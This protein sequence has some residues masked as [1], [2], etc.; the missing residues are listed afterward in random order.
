MRRLMVA[1]VA[2]MIGCYVPP[3]VSPADPDAVP[4][5]KTHRPLVT[6][7]LPYHL[8]R[9]KVRA[10]HLANGWCM[11]RVWTNT[12]EFYVCLPE[13]LNLKTPPMYAMARYDAEGG[14]IAYATFTPVPCRMYGRCDSVYGRTVYAGEH[15]FVDHSNGLYDRLSERA[16]ADGN[17]TVELPSMQMKM[18]DALAAELRRRFGIPQWQDPHRFGAMWSTPTSQI[19]LF[20][21]GKGGWVVE[22]HELRGAAPA[23]T[24]ASR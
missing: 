5:V 6:D 2:V 23:M 14:T 18:F 21:A 16:R 15:E 3:A 11:R 13:Y 4:E 9:I 17:S 24:S 1:V 12:D 20:V 7:Q 8:E 10:W 19:G 22:T